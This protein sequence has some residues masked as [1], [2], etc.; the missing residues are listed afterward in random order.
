MTCAVFLNGLSVHSVTVHPP[1]DT[2]KFLAEAWAILSRKILPST[3]LHVLE[4][5]NHLASI[6]NYVTSAACGLLLFS[7]QVPRSAQS[8]Q[9]TAALVQ[10][11]PAAR[12]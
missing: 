3:S 5:T 7:L 2:W 11:P 8:S 12:G 4:L 9:A 1:A 10:A 6:L